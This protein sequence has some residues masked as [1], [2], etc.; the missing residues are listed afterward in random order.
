MLMLPQH[1]LLQSI[2]GF[3]QTETFIFECFLLSGVVC[4]TL[5]RSKQHP[6]RT[7]SVL[8]VEEEC[9]VCCPGFPAS[10]C[11]FPGALTPFLQLAAVAVFA[12]ILHKGNF[13]RV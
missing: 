9:C 2:P 10:S 3:L 12:V 8:S 7:V 4:D 13:R 1:A 11:Q 6:F 5:T